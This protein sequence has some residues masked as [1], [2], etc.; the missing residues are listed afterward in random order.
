[1]CVKIAI[2]FAI[3]ARLKWLI[4]S[5]TIIKNESLDSSGNLLFVLASMSK[6]LLY[7][8][9]SLSFRLWIPLVRGQPHGSFSIRH[10]FLCPSPWAT[11]PPCCTWRRRSIS[12]TVFLD[13]VVHERLPR[14]FVWHSHLLLSV[15]YAHT[16][17]AWPRV[18]C[19]W[20]MLLIYNILLVWYLIYFFARKY[21][22]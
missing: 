6:N 1:M 21:H 20:C 19:P 3:S 11:S 17:S 10:D 22:F 12:F 13:F 7:N 15:V 16:I 2:R 4:I 14:G 9:F 5:R 18:P 8:I